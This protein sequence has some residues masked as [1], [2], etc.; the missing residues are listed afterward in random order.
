[1]NAHYIFALQN[2]KFPRQAVIFSGAKVGSIKRFS[3]NHRRADPNLRF[4]IDLI[5]SKNGYENEVPFDP[6]LAIIMS[7]LLLVVHLLLTLSRASSIPC[8]DLP[9]NRGLLQLGKLSVPSDLLADSG[10]KEISHIISQKSHSLPDSTIEVLRYSLQEDPTMQTQF[11]FHRELIPKL[12]SMELFPHQANCFE[13]GNT[14]YLIFAIQGNPTSIMTNSKKILLSIDVYKNMLLNIVNIYKSFEEEGAIITEIYKISFY[15]SSRNKL[16]FRPPD[17]AFVY[18]LGEKMCFVTNVPANSR[19]LGFPTNTKIPCGPPPQRIQKAPDM[20][21]KILF[22]NCMHVIV[23]NIYFSAVRPSSD[24]S[25]IYFDN[26]RNYKD[27]IMEYINQMSRSPSQE[28]AT[29]ENF[30][31]IIITNA[32]K[33]I[34]DNASSSSSYNSGSSSRSRSSSKE[35]KSVRNHHGTSR[36]VHG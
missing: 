32:N 18:K 3:S 36:N 5:K 24:D 35:R 2:L 19:A 33:M 17:L 4:I 34:S 10:W 30:K 15:L 14:K 28:L 11:N 31:K 7:A 12:K 1:M 29:W 9:Q 26:I 8:Q 20:A 27:I 13:R 22:L 23:Q 25:K 21:F 16:S 6:H